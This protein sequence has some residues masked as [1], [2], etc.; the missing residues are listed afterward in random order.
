MSDV[1]EQDVVYDS[2]DDGANHE[3]GNEITETEHQRSS[4][5]DIEE[6]DVLYDIIDD[7]YNNESNNEITE[8]EYQRT[9]M[10][11]DVEEQDVDDGSNEYDNEFTETEH[12]GYFSSLGKSFES[13]CFGLVM[14][15]GA[16]A[17]LCWNEYRAL[18][19]LTGIAIPTQNLRDPDFGVNAF[20]KVKLSRDISSYQWYETS[21]TKK[22]KTADGGTTT[23]TTYSYHK[24][25]VDYYVRS[26][27]FKRSYGHYNPPWPFHDAT[28]ITDV[29]LGSFDLP[30]DMIDTFPLDS[31]PNLSFKKSICHDAEVVKS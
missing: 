18:V 30:K 31:T 7:G 29:T 19:Y 9:S 8:T 5:S 28:Y 1:E 12:Q 6:Q 25:W 22:K 14:F 23:I 3:Y 13:V 4:M 11:E 20:L 15:V 26:S 24:R 17:L 10:S 21:K 2:V 16:F 27:A